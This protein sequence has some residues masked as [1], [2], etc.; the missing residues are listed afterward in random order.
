MSIR[1]TGRAKKTSTDLVLTRILPEPGLIQTR[2]TAFLRL[3]VASARPCASTFFS[4]F[5]AS[6]A[7]G[8]RVASPS[9][10]CT[11]SATIRHSSRSCDS[12]Q[13]HRA[14][15]V[16]APHAD[17]RALDRRANFQAERGQAVRAATCALRPSRQ[18]V[19]GNALPV[20]LWRSAL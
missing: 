4:Y 13:Q 19:P 8:L 18:C 3:A 14:F 15:Q 9:R 11:V 12:S 17:A 16:S 1:N 2:A 10:D 20:L 6:G 5:G 7:A